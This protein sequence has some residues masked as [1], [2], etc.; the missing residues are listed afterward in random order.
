MSTNESRV[1]R[2]Y[3]RQTLSAEQRESERQRAFSAVNRMATR[4]FKEKKN[5]NNK[6]ESFF[7]PLLNVYINMEERERVGATETNFIWRKTW[8]FY[9]GGEKMR[10]ASGHQ[11]ENERQSNKSEQEQ[12]QHFLHRT[13]VTR[14]FLEVSLCSHAK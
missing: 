1:N 14:K 5:N 3:R 13:H 4:A 8:K 12:I 10:N 9:S 11:G 7:R 2:T 6:A